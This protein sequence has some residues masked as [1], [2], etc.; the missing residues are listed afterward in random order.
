MIHP[1]R[2]GQKCRVIKSA[3]PRG[4]SIG[5]EVVTRWAHKDRLRLDVVQGGRWVGTTDI[6]I[7]WRVSGPELVNVPKHP[8]QMGKVPAD[9]ADI[10]AVWL[11]VI[12]GWP[13]VVAGE[14]S[15]TVDA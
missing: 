6:G 14:T 1:T 8:G 11:E 10:P 7:V 13:L 4:L 12:D 2:P 9:Q 3:S 5:M 15:K